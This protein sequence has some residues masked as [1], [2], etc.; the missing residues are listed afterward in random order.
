MAGTRR[1][2]DSS[3]RDLVTD[4]LQ[5]RGVVVRVNDEETNFDLDVLDKACFHSV[6]FAK[7]NA[8]DEFEG[9]AQGELNI[10]QIIDI[11]KD[12]SMSVKVVGLGI[13][14]FLPWDAIV[15]KDMLEQLPLIGTQ[16]N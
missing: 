14:E 6:L 15:M 1:A 9:I 3:A 4:W 16:K 2:E 7:P 10:I 12:V 5:D 11:L 13:T 8:K